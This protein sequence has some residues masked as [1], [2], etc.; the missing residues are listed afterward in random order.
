M[1]VHGTLNS[2]SSRGLIET[3]LVLLSIS[4]AF[5]SSCRLRWLLV[6]LTRG[7]SD[8]LMLLQVRVRRTIHCSTTTGT[9]GLIFLFGARR[10]I[11]GICFGAQPGI[12]RCSTVFRGTG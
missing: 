4:M 12:R 1:G 5:L 9:G 6:T 10:I 3:P 11:F 2:D 8:R 7:L